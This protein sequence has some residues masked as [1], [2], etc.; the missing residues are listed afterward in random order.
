MQ[1]KLSLAETIDQ[2]Q[3]YITT[4]YSKY[5]PVSGPSYDE[6]FRSEAIVAI[7]EH[8]DDYNPDKGSLTTFFAPHIKHA[9]QGFFDTQ[10][11]KT[12]GHYSKKGRDIDRAITNLKNKGIQKPTIAQISVET[13][14]YNPKSVVS[15]STIYTYMQIDNARS[16]VRLDDDVSE[17]VYS[18]KSMLT[19]SPEQVFMK[20]EIGKI[21]S[22]ALEKLPEAEKMA[23]SYKF[24]FI[25]MDVD[26]LADKQKAKESNRTIA[27][28]M[29][30]APEQV[31]KLINQGMMKLK[32]D[33]SLQNVF[34][35][36]L[37]EKRNS[38]NSND[39]YFNSVQIAESQMNAFDD[40]FLSGKQK[41]S[42][43]HKKQNID[44][45][46]YL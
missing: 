42:K 14:R 43:K 25:P 31:K 17:Q 12:T 24:H 39:I 22:K 29:G 9:I 15:V 30:I 7:C 28:Q 4:L 34:N 23:I 35:D 8:Y 41:T 16:E 6:D 20:E 13:G 11:C 32:R 10:I 5:R 3:A 40:L 26:L 2:L 44:G 36:E 37:K 27:L 38:K 1:K 21:V 45:D 33:I 19:M 18:N 46:F